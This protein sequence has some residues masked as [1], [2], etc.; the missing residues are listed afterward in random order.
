MHFGQAEGVAG[1]VNGRNVVRIVD[2]GQ[3]QGQI[4]LAVT[5]HFKQARPAPGS[6]F[7]GHAD[8]FLTHVYFCNRPA[9]SEKIRLL[10]YRRRRRAPH[11]ANDM[12]AAMQMLV[13]GVSEKTFSG[14][15]IAKG[16]DLA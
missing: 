5:Q 10:L 2:V 8:D 3:H 15:R 1:A 12:A 4:V 11:A 14:K 6:G 9:R 7:L 13:K 16:V